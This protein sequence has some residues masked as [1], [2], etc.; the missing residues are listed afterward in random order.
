LLPA[1][2]TLDRFD[3]I[4]YDGLGKSGSSLMRDFCSTLTIEDRTTGDKTTDVAHMNHPV[5]FGSGSWL[6]FQAQWDPQGQRWTVLGIG[7]RPGVNVMILG[8]VLIVCGLLYA[9][10][11]KPLIIRRMKRKRGKRQ[12]RR[13]PN[14]QKSL[15][16]RFQPALVYD[17]S[18]RDISVGSF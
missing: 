2:L 9:F 7:N 14:F 11:A 17:L 16:P 1:R 3:A 4:P 10:Y 6:F 15:I 8:C 13:N 5:Y 18:G 12:R